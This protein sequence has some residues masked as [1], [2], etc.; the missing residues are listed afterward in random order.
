MTTL[1]ATKARDETRATVVVAV[2]RPQEQTTVAEGAPCSRAASR[3]AQASGNCQAAAEHNNRWT[4]SAH[5]IRRYVRAKGVLD[6]G[7]RMIVMT[8]WFR[9]ASH[10]NNIEYKYSKVT[11]ANLLYM[12]TGHGQGRLRRRG[13][14]TRDRRER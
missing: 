4:Q 5:Q 13:T 12:S 3:A 6:R 2:E 7:V 1:D 10:Y 14:T 8:R 9:A 11:Y